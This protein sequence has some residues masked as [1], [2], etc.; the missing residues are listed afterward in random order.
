MN[1]KC[2]KIILISIVNRSIISCKFRAIFTNKNFHSLNLTT[3][4]RINLEFVFFDENIIKKGW[5]ELTNQPFLYDI[6]FDNDHSFGDMGIWGHA[7]NASLNPI[8]QY[9][10]NIYN[11]N[12]YCFSICRHTHCVYT[13]SKL[14]GGIDR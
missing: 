8:T 9:L 7:A 6:L 2:R 13:S 11:A 3:Q 1:I 10:F 12:R 5:F 14:V 4:I